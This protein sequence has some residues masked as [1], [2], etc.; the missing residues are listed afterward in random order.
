M[1]IV[2]VHDLGAV[3]N[4]EIKAT[5]KQVEEL[6]NEFDSGNSSIFAFEKLIEKKG[7]KYKTIKISGERRMC[8]FE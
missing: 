8:F 1:E 4:I 2:R 5:E 7:Y 3:Y 6:K